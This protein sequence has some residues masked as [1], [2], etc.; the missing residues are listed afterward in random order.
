MGISTNQQKKPEHQVNAQIPESPKPTTITGLHMVTEEVHT[1]GEKPKVV[2]LDGEEHEK[3][4]E[5]KT[6]APSSSSG[7]MPLVLGIIAVIFFIAYALFWA[8]ILGF[9]IFPS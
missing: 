4:D 3:R 9:P 5:H 1:A 6:E 8:Q 7:I 2:H